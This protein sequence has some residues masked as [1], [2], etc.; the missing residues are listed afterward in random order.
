MRP[1]RLMAA[2]TPLIYV[3]SRSGL[4]DPRRAGATKFCSP[5]GLRFLSCRAVAAYRIKPAPVLLN[6]SQSHSYRLDCFRARFKRPGASPAKVS[7]IK[8]N[9]YL[10]CKIS[11]SSHFNRKFAGS[12]GLG[13]SQFQ[14]AAGL[15]SRLAA[16]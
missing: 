1:R 5:M 13:I 11:T 8:T 6:F 3:A 16:V 2:I 9:L 4:L 14:D 15:C 7:R 12:Y 10:P